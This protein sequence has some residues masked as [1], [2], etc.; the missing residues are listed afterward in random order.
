MSFGS[1]AAAAD[2]R[3]F[4]QNGHLVMDLLMLSGAVHSAWHSGHDIFIFRSLCKYN[5][6]R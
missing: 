3:G 4:P 1:A 2:G 6:L 5:F